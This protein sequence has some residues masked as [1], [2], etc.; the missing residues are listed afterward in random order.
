[1]NRP[2][3]ILD[4]RLITVFHDVIEC[5]NDQILLLTKKFPDPQILS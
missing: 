2:A 5:G 1:M 4:A 3:R